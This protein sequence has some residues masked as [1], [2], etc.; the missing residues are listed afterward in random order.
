MVA[1]KN[2]D[3]VPEGKVGVYVCYCGGNISDQ[4]DVEKVCER[5]RQVPGVVVARSNM[6]MCSD[7]GQELII[8]D[9]KSGLVD[10]VVVAPALP[11]CMKPLFVRP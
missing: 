3:P 10:R 2:P 7:P 4:V 5:A 8:E 6:F 1:K 11:V 9:L